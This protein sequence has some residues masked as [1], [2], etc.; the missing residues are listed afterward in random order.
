MSGLW[1]LLKLALALYPFMVGAMAINLFM[2]SLLWA[3]VGFPVLNPVRA[4]TGGCIIAIPV[5]YVFARRV[6]DLIA[7]ANRPL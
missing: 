6:R 2:L 7:Q 5:S 3:W 4:T 1:S